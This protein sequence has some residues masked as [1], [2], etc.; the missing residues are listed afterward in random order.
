MIK[1]TYPFFTRLA[2]CSYK[3]RMYTYHYYLPVAEMVWYEAEVFLFLKK[4][5]KLCW[6]ENMLKDFFQ[7]LAKAKNK[8]LNKFINL[9]LI[10]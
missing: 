6:L 3:V 2:N 5:N 9:I 10:F 4:W 8:M 7:M 1:L